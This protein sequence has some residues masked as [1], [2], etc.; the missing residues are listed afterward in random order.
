MKIFHLPPFLITLEFSS[1]RENKIE[2]MS[3]MS[4]HFACQVLKKNTLFL[5]LTHV[6][7]T[8]DFEVL[9]LNTK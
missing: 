1:K 5:L 8:V 4:D 3:K 6:T 7:K 2:L 9:L